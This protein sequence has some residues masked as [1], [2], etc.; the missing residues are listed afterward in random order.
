MKFEEEYLRFVEGHK[1][2]RTGERLRRLQEGHFIRKGCSW[3][4][5]GGL[6]SPF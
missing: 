2:K 5:F 3:K 6:S 4:R 1:Q